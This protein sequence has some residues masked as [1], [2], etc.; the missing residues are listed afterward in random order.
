MPTRYW[1]PLAQQRLRRQAAGCIEDRR[2]EVVKVVG[3]M[4]HVG[5]AD[6][7]TN[8]REQRQDHQRYY[9]HPRAL[10]RSAVSV[11]AASVCVLRV[12]DRARVPCVLRVRIMS[13]TGGLRI[14]PAVLAKEG[15]EPQPEHVERGHAGGDNADQPQRMIAAAPR[16]HRIRSL[17]KKPAKGGMPAMAKVA[18]VM[19]QN[20]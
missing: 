11:A 20:V 9:H 1:I 12:M 18:H 13:V 3:A 14:G 19:H 4:Q 6:P 10:M 5:H 16:C 7:S 17:E 15:E 2:E 8:Q